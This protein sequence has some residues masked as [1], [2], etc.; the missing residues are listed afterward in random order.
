MRHLVALP[1]A[2]S[3]SFVGLPA[4]AAPAEPEAA[5]PSPE[6]DAAPSEPAPEVKP[7]EKIETPDA[8]ASD[9]PADTPEAADREQAA[10]AFGKGGDLYELGKYPEAVEKF[11]LAWELSHEVQLLYNIGQAYWKWFD[12]DPDIDHLRQARLFF[13]NYDKRMRLTEGYDPTEVENV[14]KAIEAQIEAERRRI[15]EANRPKEIIVQGPTGESEEEIRKKQRRRTTKALNASG[16]T[17]IVLGSLS[18]GVGLG[19]LASRFA[20][21]QVLNSTSNNDAMVSLLTAD[22]DE[23]RRDQYLLSGQIAF[24]GLLAAAVML[25]V[26]IALRVSGAVRIKRDRERARAERGDKA[27]TGRGDD[28]KKKGRKG[29]KKKDKKA[30]AYVV[31]SYG[32]LT[33]HF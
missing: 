28:G 14:L 25:P 7:D 27:D 21:G 20:F 17:L 6:P 3:L 9:A 1:L 29:R 13:T 22:E 30:Q 5:A 11:Q 16:N 10:E 24:G 19:A 23:R 31:P 18:L 2:L 32:G 33:V 8:P 15:E 26:G 4:I 12:V